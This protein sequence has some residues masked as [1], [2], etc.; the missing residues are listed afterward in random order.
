MIFVRGAH[1]STTAGSTNKVRMKIWV[2]VS[3]DNMDIGFS[4]ILFNVLT[5]AFHSS[6]CVRNWSSFPFLPRPLITRKFSLCQHNRQAFTLNLLLSFET[7]KHSVFTSTLQSPPLPSSSSSTFHAPSVPLC[8][9][10]MRLNVM[11]FNKTRDVLER[12]MQPFIL[13]FLLPPHTFISLSASLFPFLFFLPRFV[14]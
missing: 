6:L 11:K 1:C 3:M 2:V 12:S 13:F 10:Q 4:Y 7:S 8:N 9:Q 5:R 14:T